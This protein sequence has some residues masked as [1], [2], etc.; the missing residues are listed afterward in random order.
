MYER[1]ASGFVAGFVGVSN[2]I[3]REG[4]S[5]AIRPEKIRMLDLPAGGTRSDEE[6]GRI[7]EVVYAGMV[8]RYL[9]ELDRGGELQVVRQNLETSS[10]EVLDAKGRNVVL[11]WR[12]EHQL[13]ID[14]EPG[15]TE[16][17]Q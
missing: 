1:P 7:R 15:E 17:E 8:T 3:E 16:G 5:F 6:T 11:E 10:A 2:V 13:E 9:V 14:P 4:K 12:P